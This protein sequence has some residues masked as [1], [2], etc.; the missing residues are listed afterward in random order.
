MSSDQSTI[1]VSSPNKIVGLVR[2]DTGSSIASDATA[3][4][5]P[6]PGR[7][8][9]RLFT[10]LGRRLES[11]IN[12]T[13]GQMNL[14]PEAVAEKIRLLCRH[15]ETSEVER[16]TSSVGPLSKAERKRL[17]KLCKK[18][19]KYARSVS[20]LRTAFDSLDRS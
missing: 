3:D 13:A 15:Y 5:L 12:T 18:L 2:V 7:N 11:M 20:F 1:A 10:W 8:V 14:G 17:N 19:L 16:L 4:N 9:G 6:G